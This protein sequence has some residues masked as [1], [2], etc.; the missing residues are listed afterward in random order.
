MTCEGR[1]CCE[2]HECITGQIVRH[3]LVFSTV[4]DI[5]YSSPSPS[6]SFSS[7][8]FFFFLLLSLSLSLSPSGNPVQRDADGNIV[9]EK[10][11]NIEQIKL[12]HAEDEHR[13]SQDPF[14]L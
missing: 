10:I 9:V 1:Y 3:S 7:F 11:G 5:S 8:F 13:L 12:R 6:P 2:C 14:P 4:A